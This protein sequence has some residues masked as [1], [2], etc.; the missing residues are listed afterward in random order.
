MTPTK[1]NLAFLFH[2]SNLIE[3]YDDPAFDRQQLVAK[4]NVIWGYDN[5]YGAHLPLTVDT[6]DAPDSES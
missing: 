6:T 3:G 4:K 5:K 2:E 1:K